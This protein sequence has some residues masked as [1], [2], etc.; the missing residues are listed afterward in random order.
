[1]SVSYTHLLVHLGRIKD[2]KRKVL[3][4]SEVMYADDD[5]HL[6]LLYEYHAENGLVRTGNDM[7]DCSK[8]ERYG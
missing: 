5:I 6:N 8:L 3:N 7:N 2:G 1:M 4:I